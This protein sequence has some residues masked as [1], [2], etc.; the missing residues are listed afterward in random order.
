MLDSIQFGPCPAAMAGFVAVT[1]DGDTLINKQMV[2]MDGN[3]L[4]Y[5]NNSYDWN[6]T[7]LEEM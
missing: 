6:D 4:Y 7:I 1:E 3:D 2:V 5:L